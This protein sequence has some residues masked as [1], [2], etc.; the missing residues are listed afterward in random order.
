MSYFW[1]YT[2]FWQEMNDLYEDWAK[3]HGMSFSEL[4]VALSLVQ[5]PK[6][7]RQSDICRHWALPKQT[8]NSVLKQ[9]QKQE[10]V[11]FA[12]DELDRR[13]RRVSLTSHGAAHAGKIARQLIEM[14]SQV[15]DKMGAE[16]AQLLLETTQ[17][18]NRYFREVF[19]DERT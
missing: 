1:E 18:Y 15:W 14:E 19:E 6:G 11:T 17:Q 2:A 7:C 16:T 13:A 12:R 5:Q 8:V 10:W 4:L 9:W 3:R